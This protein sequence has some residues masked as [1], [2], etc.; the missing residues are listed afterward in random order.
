MGAESLGVLNL[1]AGD[2]LIGILAE[3]ALF[4]VL[5]T[6]G[7]K[8]G[9][10]D[11]SSGF[12]QPG[13]A[14]LFGLPLTLL[15]TAVLAHTMVDLPWR[16]SLLL[17]AILS[18]TDPVL[19]SAIV[20][21]TKVPRSLRHLL[22]VESGLND[23]LA[24]PVVILLIRILQGTPLGL[25]SFVFEIAGGIVLGVAIPW[26][27]VKAE[28]SRYFGASER[29]TAL[30]PF[31]SGI[32]VFSLCSVLHANEYLAAFSAGVTIAS[33]SED[34]LRES[35]G[36]LEPVTEVLKLAALFV[37]G[38]LFSVS[39]LSEVSPAG[40]AFAVAALIAVR[41]IALLIALL[42]RPLPK[43]QFLAAA[44][45]GPKGFASVVYSLL[46]LRSGIVR[47]DELFHLAAIVVGLSI[48]AHSST[49]VVVAKR[50]IKTDAG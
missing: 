9:I 23:G 25:W 18:P 48:I 2:P 40:Y 15:G 8:I 41:P 39:F 50:L 20:G 29:Y 7:M 32:L 37:F 16:E 5:F 45:F 44:W 31:A 19:V 3:L 1:D 42:G 22:N 27:I 10:R 11:L 38:A 21:N 28:R 30:V 35:E 49:D 24:L 14:L 43:D 17:G 13:R 47:A 46:L 34:M 6:D 33:I 12:H 26:F 4:S 36:F